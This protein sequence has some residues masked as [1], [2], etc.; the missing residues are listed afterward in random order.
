M[1]EGRYTDA[2]KDFSAA[3]EI[4]ETRDFRYF[5]DPPAFWYPVRRDVAAAL[6][7]AGDPAGA[8]A[9]ASASLKLRP[10][11]PVAMVLLERAEAAIRPFR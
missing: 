8:R 2:A 11:D 6:L 1:I 5:S 9:A 3:A 7:A 10:R 4:E